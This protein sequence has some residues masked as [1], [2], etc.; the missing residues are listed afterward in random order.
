MQSVTIVIPVYNRSEYLPR[1]FASLENVTYSGMKVILVDNGSTDDSLALCM[2]F[3][4][5][6]P[7]PVKVLQEHRKGA[8]RARNTGL[9]A[10]DTDWV[11]F[12][13]SDDEVSPDFLDELMPLTENQ[14][15]LL[16][17]TRQTDGRTIY[18]RPYKV[19]GDGG[20]QILSSM[21]NT[22]SMLLR[23]AWVRNIGGWDESLT[24]WDDWELGIRVLL[25]NPR[26]KWYTRKPFHTIYLHPES[27]T[28]VSMSSNLEGKKHCLQTVCRQLT[29]KRHLDALY[30]RIKIIE[31]Q[32]KREGTAEKLDNTVKDRGWMTCW[33]GKLLSLY[34][35]MGGRGAWQIACWLS[36]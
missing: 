11:Y 32:L 15:A 23:T 27:I 1:L 10:C 12:F 17:T 9:K 26:I 36:L 14:D 33:A 25:N 20:Y 7:F 5:R 29:E 28:G 19:S 3:S 4:E 22:P 30:L 24:V 35:A 8:A 16:L 6:V 34:T 21:L 31:G 18:T 13:D 2:A